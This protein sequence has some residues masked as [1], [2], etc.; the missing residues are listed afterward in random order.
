[1]VFIVVGCRGASPYGLW[2]AED[3]DPYGDVTPPIHAVGCFFS[4]SH[5]KNPLP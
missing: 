1:M 4:L 3:V 5:L 2:V